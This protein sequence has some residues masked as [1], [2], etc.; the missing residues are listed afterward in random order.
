MP[1]FILSL[2]FPQMVRG[3]NLQTQTPLAKLLQNKNHYTWKKGPGAVSLDPAY[4]DWIRKCGQCL[5]NAGEHGCREDY[6]MSAAP[7][8]LRQ[9]Q[10]LGSL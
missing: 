5:H 3:V 6:R 10:N 4:L 9:I 1:T 7:Q 8:G 2:D